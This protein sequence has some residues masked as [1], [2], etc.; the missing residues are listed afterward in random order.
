VAARTL[1]Q[2]LW[3]R[4]LVAE[5]DGGVS[6]LH[7]D[8]H[9]LHDLEA[10]PGLRRIAARGY[11]V[12]DP[13]LT[14]VTPDHT[15]PS[16]AGAAPAGRSSELLQEMR[17]RTA[18]A[19]I[20]LFDVGEPGH[21]IVH[22][23]AP[24]LG[25]TLPGL[26]VACPDSHTCTHG[27]LGALGLAIGASEVAHVLATQTLRQRRPRSMRIVY[28]GS[29]AAGVT[30]KDLILA[31]IG[32]LGTDAGRGC[33][34]EYAGEPIERLS[35]DERLTVCNLSIELGARIGVIAPDETTFAYVEGRPHA[36]AGELFERAVA[37][38][39]TLASDE[40][41]AFDVEHAIDAGAVAPQV[42]WGTSPQD[43]IPVDGRIPEPELEPDARRR[44]RMA[45]AL[46][47]MGLAPGAPIAGTPVDWVFVGS[48]TNARLSD[49]RAAA[50]A[51]AGHRVAPGVR[52]WVVPGSEATKRAAEAEGLDE[53][54][55]EAGFEWR[56]PG[57]S[58][59]L[60]ANGDAVPPGQR[61]VSTTNRNFVGRQGPG[62]RTHLASPQTAVAA[63]ITGVITDPRA[64]AA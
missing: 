28:E 26:T 9:Y 43:V 33:A 56:L 62:A 46:A 16:D 24:E 53:V 42:S 47:Y 61:S 44:R 38:W 25:L 29:L 2:K 27:G 60:A 37:D 20:R 21:G 17:E 8:R 22:V 40:G 15:V 30:A 14:F 63:A 18:E 13:E 31:T 1:F 55:R 49:L 36:P 45:D 51:L 7:V 50:Q 32:K 64:L 41:A 48:C 4:H 39:R 3:E 12:H 57:C 58:M 35:V 11:R 34:V 54:F 52:A 23:I 59:C 10:G 19:G 6:L 5:L